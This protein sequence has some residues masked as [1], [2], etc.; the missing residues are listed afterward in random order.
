MFCWKL[1]TVTV[2]LFWTKRNWLCDRWNIFRTQNLWR[3][4]RVNCSNKL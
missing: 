2:D 1:H 3:C 4:N